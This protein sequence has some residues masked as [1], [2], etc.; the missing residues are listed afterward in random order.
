MS[1]I[2]VLCGHLA[3]NRFMPIPPPELISCGD[4]DF[5]GIGA[6]FLGRLVRDAGLLPSHRVLDIGCGIGRL[7]LPMTQYLD[8]SGTYDGIDPLRDAIEWCAATI[9]PVYSNVR[10]QNLDLHHPRY[11]PGGI[12]DT[13]TVRLPFD[14]GTFDI[15]CMISVLTHL[16][17]PDVLRYAEETARL[18][19]PGGLCFATAFLMNPAARAALA[20]GNGCL[21]FD[22]EG[23]GP[24]YEGNAAPLAAVAFDEDVLVEKFL[25]H[26]LRRRLPVEYG[27]W[28]GRAPASFQDI[29]IFEKG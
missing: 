27:H 3:A 26:G 17:E 28:S 7:A 13:A 1:D 23:P 18:L 22:P 20:A 6:E 14:D 29:C 10:F 24:I 9:T 21:D 12:V 16:H 11:N 5:R 4:G 15:V 19:V 8:Q 2:D 25:R